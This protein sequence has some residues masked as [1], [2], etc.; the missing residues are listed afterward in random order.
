[1]QPSCAEDWS[2]EALLATVGDCDRSKKNL[3]HQDKSDASVP[4]EQHQWK[5]GKIEAI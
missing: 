4:L 2:A 3:A 1:M 5:P